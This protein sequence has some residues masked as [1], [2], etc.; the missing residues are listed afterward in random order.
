VNTKKTPRKY[1]LHADFSIKCALAL[2]FIYMFLPDSPKLPIAPVFGVVVIIYFAAFGGGLAQIGLSFDLA[3]NAKRSTIIILGIFA[4]IILGSAV[5]VSLGKASAIDEPDENAGLF[6]QESYE[7]LGSWAPSEKIHGSLNEKDSGGVI[8]QSLKPIVGVVICKSLFETLFFFGMFFPVIWRKYSYKRAL[9][10]VP[11][12]F[13]VLHVMH[14]SLVGFVI[15]Y[16]NGVLQAALYA[17]TKSLY[18]AIALHICWN[19]NIL[20]FIHFLNWGLPF[21]A[22]I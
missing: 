22:P 20:L 16:F 4:V 2:L 6:T 17:R 18:P 1:D 8:K 21:N 12:L 11:L 7:F 3:R 15:I 14:T 10:W 19:L 5:F 13:A 9:I